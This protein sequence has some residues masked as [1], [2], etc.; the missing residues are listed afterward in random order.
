MKVY[1]LKIFNLLLFGLALSAGSF[2]QRCNI[3]DSLEL[4]R[5]FQATGGTQWSTPWYLTRPVKTWEGVMLSPAGRVTSIV[6]QSSNV[7]GPLIDLNLPELVT[8]KL[9]FNKLSGSIP[10]FTKLYKLETLYLSTNTFTGAMPAFDNLRN[11]DNINLSGNQLTGQI[12]DLRL[13]TLKTL[14]LSTNS[15]SGEIPKVFYLSSLKNLYI[16]NNRLSGS[17]SDFFGLYQLEMLDLSNNSLSGK[18]PN[19]SA[20]PHLRIL[21]LSKNKLEGSIPDFNRMA[22]LQLLALDNNNLSGEITEFTYMPS[23]TELNLSHN[24]FMGKVPSFDNLYKKSSVNIS[25]NNLA[26]GGLEQH[27]GMGKNYFV[28]YSNQDSLVIKPEGNLL[29]VESGGS[30]QNVYYTWYRNEQVIA[31]SV[32][33]GNTMFVT[34]SGTYRCLMKN[35]LLG[36]FSITTKAVKMNYQPE[37]LVVKGV[38]PS[39]VKWAKLAVNTPMSLAVS[40]PGTYILKLIDTKDNKTI[41]FEQNHTVTNRKMLIFTLP[42]TVPKGKYILRVT[43]GKNFQHGFN[44]MVQ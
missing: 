28:D 18:I 16:A 12:K 39:S 17:I 4:V 37:E 29:T 19:F 14:D 36:Q 24:H 32:R 35:T 42:A 3:S 5:F 38:E 25:Y 7:R 30:E 15:L 2:G 23:L 31:S 13:Q 1:I 10:N 22:K 20:L 34:S 11:I 43:G 6:L 8:L 9:G 33:G 44:L 26:F 21:R 41:A 40:E 27:V